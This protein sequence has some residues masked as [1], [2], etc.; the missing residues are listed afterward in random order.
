MGRQNVSTGGPWEAKIGYSRAVVD[1][2][3]VF[4]SGTTGFDYATMTI[5]D[6]LAANRKVLSRILE[7]AG[8]TTAVVVPAVPVLA[9]AEDHTHVLLAGVQLHGDALE[10]APRHERTRRGLGATPTRVGQER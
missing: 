5:A 4:V 2:D 6:D 7:R 10:G 1:G 3:W 9:A 8:C